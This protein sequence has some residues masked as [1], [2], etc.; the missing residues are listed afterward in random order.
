M[1][2]KPI[3]K[4]PAIKNKTADTPPS[5]RLPNRNVYPF[6]Q[7][8]AE[9]IDEP[10]TELEYASTFELL[11]AVMLSAQATDVSVNIATNKL[12]PVANTPEAILELGEDGLKD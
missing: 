1:T 12:F 6:F 8:L 9:T 2:K 10:V 11:I 7:K 5:R 4:K 3:S